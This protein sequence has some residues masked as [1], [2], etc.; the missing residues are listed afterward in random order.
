MIPDHYGNVQHS[1]DCVT[2]TWTSRRQLS[3][4]IHDA[5]QNA[6]KAPNEGSI[7]ERRKMKHGIGT[8][9]SSRIFFLGFGNHHRGLLNLRWVVWRELGTQSTQNP[10]SRDCEETVYALL[11]G[12]RAKIIGRASGWLHS[13]LFYARDEKT[14]S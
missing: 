4:N 13:R 9:V 7:R 2:R 14:G 6:F 5:G 10:P 3:I 1:F 12:T 8:T 11:T